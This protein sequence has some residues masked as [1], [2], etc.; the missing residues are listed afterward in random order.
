MPQGLAQQGISLPRP[1]GGLNH[2]AF[3]NNSAPSASSYHLQR[4]PSSEGEVWGSIGQ[5][6]PLLNAGVVAG[7]PSW[8]SMDEEAMPQWADAEHPATLST[9]TTLRG[10]SAGDPPRGSHENELAMKALMEAELRAQAAKEVGPSP[11][12]SM[13]DRARFAV[14]AIPHCSRLDPRFPLE[15][16]AA[17]ERHKA[18]QFQQQLDE[19]KRQ[20]QAREHRHCHCL[21]P[22]PPHQRALRPPL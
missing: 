19:A 18:Q 10:N 11:A 7:F 3:A 17:T 8:G 14:A 12:V 1:L 9:W 2:V 13:P 22:I 4:V 20:E 6:S 16:E 21:S 5:A 15:Q